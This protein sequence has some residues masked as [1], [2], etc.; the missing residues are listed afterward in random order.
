MNQPLDQQVKRPAGTA[1]LPQA[2]SLFDVAE[3]PATPDTSD[4]EVEVRAKAKATQ[5]L[6]LQISAAGVIVLAL[7]W[8][9]VGQMTQPN[10]SDQQSEIPQISAETA[11]EMPASTPRRA[12]LDTTMKIYHGMDL[13]ELVAAGVYVDRLAGI[14]DSIIEQTDA[15]CELDPATPGLREEFVATETRAGIV[16]VDGG[17]KMF[18]ALIIY[19]DA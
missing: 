2:D 15:T 9:L 17:N 16:D 12:F 8:L 5:K 14:A 19:C 3:M 4:V 10:F 1:A 13:M 7:L 6:K 18:D 11:P